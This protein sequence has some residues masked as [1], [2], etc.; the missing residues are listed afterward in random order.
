MDNMSATFYESK[1]GASEKSKI[2]S[3]FQNDNVVGYVFISPWLLGF[4]AF[5]II[6]ILAS[7]F[8]SFTSYDLL[9]APK[10]TGLD[11][12]IKMF[13]NDS[14]FWKSLNVTLIY[15]VTAVPLRLIF[16]LAIAMIFTYRTRMEGLYRAIYYLPSLVGGSVA[17]AVLWKRMFGKDGILNAILSI[18]GVDSSI[19]WIGNPKTSLL[20]LIILF[21]WQFG[22]PMLIFLAGLKQIPTSLYEAANVDGAKSYQKF[23]RITLPM[24]TPI[25]FFN[26]VMQTITAFTI[27][28]QSFVISNGTGAPLDSLLLYSLYL[29]RKAFIFFDMSYGCALA[30]VLL[31]VVGITTAVL[32]ATKKLWV[33]DD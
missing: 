17:I 11:N 16:A 14:K 22:S 25:I 24:L 19:N 15:V 1:S 2:R 33:Y 18:F 29:Y 32:F 30:W 23:F 9:S 10:I 5:T 3:F 31:L 4:F 28:T 6:P 20:T 26:L 27:F 8:L 12:Y 21:V 7:L 13:T